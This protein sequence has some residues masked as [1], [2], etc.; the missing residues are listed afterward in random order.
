MEGVGIEMDVGWGV[1]M[2]CRGCVIMKVWV[3]GV[4]GKMVLF[5]AVYWVGVIARGCALEV[6]M[7]CC[8]IRA[9]RAEAKLALVDRREDRNVVTPTLGVALTL[10]VVCVVVTAVPLQ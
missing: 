9:V 3:I 10:L 5:G 1:L 2:V 6:W 4:T 8:W 7:E